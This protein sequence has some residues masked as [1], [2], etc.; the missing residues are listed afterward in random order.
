[1]YMYGRGKGAIIRT[2]NMYVFWGR[3]EA[4]GEG[5]GWVGKGLGDGGRG[6]G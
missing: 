5:W 1:M 2:Y 6:C 3:K 4:A